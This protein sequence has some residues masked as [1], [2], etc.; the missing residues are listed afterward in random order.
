MQNVF[1]IFLRGQTPNAMQSINQLFFDQF[2]ASS[3]RLY[4]TPYLSPVF[5]ANNVDWINDKC[6]AMGKLYN[7]E[8]HV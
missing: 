6:N 8:L 7:A 4:T 3:H 2:Q 1:N 5:G